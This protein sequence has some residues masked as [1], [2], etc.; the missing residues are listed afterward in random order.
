KQHT[1]T[2]LGGNA[3]YFV[4]PTAYEQV[5]DVI[6]L[7]NQQD[8]PL[9]LLGNGS[10]LI[11]KDGGMRGIVMYLGK[12]DQIIVQNESIIAQ[13][14]DMLR[15]VSKQ[16]LTSHLTGLDFARGIPGSVGGV[17]FMNAGVYGG[18]IKDVLIQATVVDE[19]GVIRTVTAEEL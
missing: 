2:K 8:I 6:K 3:D 15:D 14:G 4:T 11:I 10:N 7:A 5:S 13:R 9:M 18:E 12:L 17:L 19:T 1:Y 16:S